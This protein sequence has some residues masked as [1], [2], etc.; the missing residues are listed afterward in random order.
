LPFLICIPICKAPPITKLGW[1]IG[2]N[3]ENKIIGP[4]IISKIAIK[5]SHPRDFIVHGCGYPKIT[6]VE[7]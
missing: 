7:L 5:P 1:A 6:P 2:F 4:K 3:P